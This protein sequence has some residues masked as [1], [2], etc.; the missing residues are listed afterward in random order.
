[1]E[2]ARAHGVDMLTFGQYLQPSRDHL[3][4]ARFVHPDEF[5]A[6]R[7]LGESMG[8]SNVAS[9]ADGA[10]VVPRRP[11]GR[12]RARDRLTGRGARPAGGGPSVRGALKG[13]R[14]ADR[15]MC[16][17]GRVTNHGTVTRHADR[18]SANG[19]R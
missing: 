15:G 14:F 6:L 11:A 2:D 7:V 17:A 13:D 10:L 18:G 16:P 19:S 12:G 3:P 5:D 9:G 4:V 8:F 1:M